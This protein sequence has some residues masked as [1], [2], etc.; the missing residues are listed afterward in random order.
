MH[1]KSR[2]LW[3][4]LFL[5]QLTGC[6]GGLGDIAQGGIDGTGL[7][8]GPISKFGSIF[9]NGIE[10][11]TSAAEISINGEAGSPEQ[12][13]L[14]MYVDV[15]GAQDQTE[16][17]GTVDSLEYRD[18]LRG[19]VRYIN[20]ENSNLQV[21]GLEVRVT[22]NTF[23][24]GIDSLADLQ[25]GD[26][27][28]V[29][30]S[31]LTSDGETAPAIEATLLEYLPQ[32]ADTFS[33]ISV[34]VNLDESTQSFFIGGQRFLYGEAQTLP[35][36]LSEHTRV[37]V[38]GRQVQQDNGSI[39]FMVD[40]VRELPPAPLLEG[41]TAQ[42]DGK[43]TRYVDPQNFD[44]EYRRVSLAQSLVDSLSENLRLGLSVHI[45]GT[46][47]ADGV[48]EIDSIE[49]FATALPVN[50]P[51]LLSIRA[52]GLAQHIALDAELNPQTLTV[53]GVTGLLSAETI[54][55][56]TGGDPDY[57][58]AD[59]RTG[60]YLMLLGT[61]DAPDAFQVD[62]VFRLP[63]VPANVRQ[64]MGNSSNIDSVNRQL[65]IL[66]VNVLSSE[67]T[68]HFDVS[69]DSDFQLTPPGPPVFAST[70][71]QVSAE[72]FFTQLQNLPN[73]VVYVIGDV[74]GDQVLAIELMLL[75]FEWGQ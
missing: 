28:R 3:L 10:Y 51:R 6:G 59:L 15:L 57:G 41:S 43:I 49:T 65:S 16:Q 7:G 8:I 19:Q 29:S 58:A 26:M 38:T 37:E 24:Y 44:V 68:R 48:I 22:E 34:L 71:T 23:L 47:N 64:L 12:L 70:E 21:L 62:Y 27:V 56:D 39:L 35:E 11:D 55:N 31:A 5:L 32:T 40:T 13:K 20:V 72:Q 52:S 18:L 9:V 25:V 46:S 36:V 17:Q 63:F 60:D 67:Q 50:P 69:N 33:V 14:G 73:Q 30:G 61:L 45:S 74:Q 42:I 75:P 53:F 54:Y 1:I 2:C 4:L 66:G